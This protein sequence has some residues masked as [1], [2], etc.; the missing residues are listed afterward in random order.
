MK[1]KLRLILLVDDYDGANFLHQKV[2]NESKCTEKVHVENSA[3][4]AI[5]FLETKQND[6]YP[7]PDII[8]IDLNMPGMN[9]WEILEEYSKLNREQRWGAVI[10]ILTT[11]HNPDDVTTARTKHPKTV[12]MNKPL[13]RTSLNE[14]LREYFSEHY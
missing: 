9:G 3:S 8:F 12:F 4:A 7:Q 6:A 2:I 1:K 11:S 10:V 14:I 13:L 5:E